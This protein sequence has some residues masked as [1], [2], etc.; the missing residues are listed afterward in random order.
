MIGTIIW[1]IVAGAIIGAL[2]RL[3]LPGRQ[4]ISVW[5]TIGVGIA[6]AL[7][8]GVLAMW[9]GV[10]ATRGVDWIRHLIQVALA[11]LFV[12]LAARISANR[13]EPRRV[14]R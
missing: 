13:P 10:G 3:V 9:L 5:A 2:G 8:G 1:A 4:N 7:I 14:T 11:A 12:A 6:A